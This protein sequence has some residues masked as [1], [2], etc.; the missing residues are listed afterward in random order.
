MVVK[1]QGAYTK[2]A[3][4]AMVAREFDLHARLS[5]TGCAHILKAWASSVRSRREP[6]HLAYIY[7]D[8]APFGTLQDLYRKYLATGDE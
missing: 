4:T 1:I 8:W 2:E 3:A 6:P 5:G 7:M